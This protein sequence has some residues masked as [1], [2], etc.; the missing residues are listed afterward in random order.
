MPIIT[1]IGIKDNNDLIR[2]TAFSF[3]YN[4]GNFKLERSDSTQILIEYPEEDMSNWYQLDI[5]KVLEKLAS[6]PCYG[7]SDREASRRL[8]QYGLNELVEQRLKS[9]WQILWEQ[10]KEALVLILLLAAG[11]SVFLGDYKNGLGIMAIVVLI[12]CLGFSQEYRAQKALAQLRQLAVPTVKVRRS[13]RLQELSA[14][15]L[16][17]GDIILLEAGELV[18]ADCRLIESWGLRTSEAALTGVAEPVDKDSEALPGKDLGIGKRRNMV[19]L[20]TVVTY[21]RAR[22]VVTET[23]MNT[24]SG[25]IASMMEK[26]EPEPTPLQKRLARLGSK[27]AIASLALVGLILILGLLRGEDVQ[28]M[29]LTAITLI[30]A[31]LPEGLP[32]VVTIAL[33]LGAQKML[34]RRALIRN[35]PAVEVLGSVTTICSGKTGTLTQNRMT[36]TVLDVAGH[37]LD[38]T[39]RLHSYSPLLEREQEQPLLL[40]QPLALSF[41]LA[42]A[43]LC[44]DA[45]LEPDPDEPRYLQ[46]VGDPTEGALVMAA[47]RQGLWK[48][49]LEQALPRVSEVPFSF[50]RQRMTTVHKIPVPFS[51][52]VALEAISYWS[53]TIGGAEYVVFTKGK[54]GSLLSVSEWVWV[55]GGVK[56]LDGNWCERIREAK[57]QFTQKGLRVLG[58]AFRLLSSYPTDSL[59]DLERELIFIGLIGIDDPMRPEAR[60][61]ILGCQQAGIRPVLVTGDRPKTA[62]HIARELDLAS[63]RLILT[64][65]ELDRLSERELESVVREVSVYAKVSPEQKLR[66]VQALQK[67]GEIVAMTGDGLNDAPALKV[68]DIGVAMGIGGTDV[69]REA[70]DLVLLDDNFTTIV[71]AVKEGRVIYDNIRK[72]IKYLLSSNVGEL[73][74]MLLAPFLGMPLPLLPLQILWINLTTDGLPALALS[75]EPAE[76]GT[77]NRPPYSPQED[78]FGRGMGRDIL[79]IGLLLGLLS[80]GT[81]YWYWRGDRSDW[82]TMLF[83]VLTLSQMG[84][85]LAIRSERDSLFQIG[86]LSNKPLLAAIVLTLG[87]Q[88]AVIYVPFL[89]Q[90][91]GTVALG[92]IDLAI[93]LAVS[94]LVFW[95]VELEKCLIR[96]S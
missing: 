78:I 15:Q 11:I 96:R 57:R 76:R 27:L 95:G 69:A 64:D 89:Q 18:P 29:F 56:P 8:K 53:R 5:E 7:L 63:D 12:A 31:A 6:D 3:R 84:N 52:P 2:L 10:L 17:P 83:T 80:L 40:S 86:L 61:A 59:E 23:G 50:R 73:W 60:D 48:S 66:I 41:L 55:D 68:A 65:K 91:F 25:R 77:M 58:V 94:T 93:S 1:L 49:E 85:A 54:I 42:G 82:Q 62:W 67:Q 34:K 35:L 13:D 28:L 74:V 36:V 47:A 26:V 30:V 70:A 21:G 43:T 88:L 37:R 71:A 20:G 9:P 19:Y 46:A 32:A 33:A 92:G 24:E 87:L 38:L 4:S 14:R 79:W 51:F 81:G 75:V 16:V 90:L 22:A 45:S 39:A 72:F 44:N